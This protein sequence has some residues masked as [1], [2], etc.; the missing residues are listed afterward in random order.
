VGQRQF[1]IGLQEA[2]LAAAVV[3]LAF[4]A[5]GKDLLAAQQR[6]DAVGELDLAAHAA[7]LVGDLVE[8]ARA[9]GCSGRPRPGARGPPPARLLDDARHVD[10]RSFTAVPATMP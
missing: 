8:D 9:S 3:A 2:F 1:H 10:Q 5:V 6:G 4:V 7:R